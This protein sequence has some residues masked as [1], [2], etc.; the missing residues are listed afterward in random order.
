VRPLVPLTY[1]LC[2]A[3]AFLLG[4]ARHRVAGPRAVRPLHHPRLQCGAAA[5][6]YPEAVPPPF[7]Y[8]R[9]HTRSTR[10]P[11]SWWH[12]PAI[13]GRRRRHCKRPARVKL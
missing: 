5:A 9:R 4:S 7:L 3:A 8:D 10:Y 11:A 13:G 12:G 2:A 1:P 6:P